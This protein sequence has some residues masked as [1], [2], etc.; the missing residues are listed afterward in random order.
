MNTRILDIG[1]EDR[2]LM[3]KDDR[4]IMV[5]KTCNGFALIRSSFDLSMSN[6]VM[7]PQFPVFVSNVIGFATGESSISYHVGDRIHLEDENEARLYFEGEELKGNRGTFVFGEPGIYELRKGTELLR[8]YTVNLTAC[9]MDVEIGGI[10]YAGKDGGK[11]W[12]NNSVP[13]LAGAVMILMIL[14]WEIFKYEY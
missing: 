12:N 11:P 10:Y 2:I 13:L 14:E 1:D 9:E 5:C 7:E 6:L 8:T 4:P 3:S